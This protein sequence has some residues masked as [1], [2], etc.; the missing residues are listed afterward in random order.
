[1]WEIHD[2]AKHTHIVETE[3]KTRRILSKEK[4]LEEVYLTG[5]DFVR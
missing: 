1:V 4:N 5:L 2:I 3:K